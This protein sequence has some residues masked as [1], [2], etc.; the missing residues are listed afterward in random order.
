MS[1]PFYVFL[2]QIRMNWSHIDP[3]IQLSLLLYFVNNSLCLRHITGPSNNLDV[4][5]ANHNA[6]HLLQSKMGGF[7]NF[8]FDERKTLMFLSDRVPRH[9]DRF[10]WAERQERLSDSVLFQFEADAANVHPAKLS[11]LSTGNWQYKKILV[12]RMIFI[13]RLRSYQQLLSQ[14]GENLLSSTIFSLNSSS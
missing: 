13:N 9:V 8:V 12:Y 4:S 7:W 3:I 14:I 5:S 11:F 1:V 10:D 2:C 6:V